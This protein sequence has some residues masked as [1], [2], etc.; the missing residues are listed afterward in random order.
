MQNYDLAIG[1]IISYR[2]VG[3]MNNKHLTYNFHVNGA[4]YSTKSSVPDQLFSRCEFDFSI[5]SSKRFWVAYQKDDPSNSLINFYLEVQ[6]IR[7]PKLP[8]TLQ[9]FR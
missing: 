4:S 8:E 6:D 1:K 7:N 5:C 3:T 2:S 9:D